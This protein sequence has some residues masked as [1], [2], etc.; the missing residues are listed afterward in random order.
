MKRTTRLAAE[1]FAYGVMVTSLLGTL[2]IT[3]GALATSSSYSV[4]ASSEWGSTTWNMEGDG[5]DT[6]S[7]KQMALSRSMASD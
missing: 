2:R 1:A 7:T 5:V 3:N 6:Q 4:V